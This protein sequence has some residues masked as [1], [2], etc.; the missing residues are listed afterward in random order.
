M[1]HRVQRLNRRIRLAA[2]LFIAAS[3]VSGLLTWYRVSVSEVAQGLV[4][5]VGGSEIGYHGKGLAAS[6]SFQDKQ[7]NLHILHTRTQ[8]GHLAV[9]QE[10]EV[11]YRADD[12][13]GSAEVNMFLRIWLIP[14]SFAF[15]G[16][17]FFA[18]RG[19]LL[20]RIAAA[21]SA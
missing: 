7:G 19:P 17:M 13:D 9:G 1:E 12:P 8:P 11:I 2:A 14:V 15:L 18:V 3:A 6:V 16:V 10:I 4:L 5:A 21:R 20:R